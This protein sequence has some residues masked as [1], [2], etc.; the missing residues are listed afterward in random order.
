M[1]W[2]EKYRPKHLTDIL[3]NTATV[4]QM[5]TWAENWTTNSAPLLLTGKPGIGK[6]STA[7]AL[8]HD[9]NWEVLE[10]NAS[11]ARTKAII[12]RIA[13]NSATTSSLFGSSRKLIIID[14]ADNLEGNADKGGTRAI[15]DLL[16][17]AKQ[18]II[19]IA[20]DAYDVSSSIR[21]LT[22]AVQFRAISTSTLGKR[23]KDICIMEQITCSDDAI[24]TIAESA[25]GDLR[26]AINMLFGAGAGN[27]EI[28][29]DDIHTSQK[30]ERATI[31][32][33]VSGIVTGIPD[34]KLQILSHEC[35]EKP[36]YVIQWIEEVVAQIPQSKHRIRAYKRVAKADIYLGRTMIRQYYT[37]WRY[38]TS[39][40]TIGVA[41][42]GKTSFYQPRVLPPRRW[43]R[44]ATAKKQKSIKRS[45]STALSESLRIPD[46]Q[47]REEYLDLLGYVA[48]A[49]PNEFCERYSLDADQMEVLIHDKE[50]AIAAFK[51]VMK[52]AKEREIKIKKVAAKKKKELDKKETETPKDS[53]QTS[54]IEEQKQEEGSAEKKQTATQATFDF[55]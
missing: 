43:K 39:L 46:T 33:L 4:R 1:D 13:G 42:E 36:D 11:D 51:S 52:T 9:M 54:V 2:A 17:S 20:N 10:L 37:L 7:L 50:R 47:I 45:L 40:M 34:S 55:F 49:N 27:K 16:K 25:K 26:S 8:A 3:G 35:E 30:D 6:T 32:E 23:L 5:V 12:E 29:A 15:A 44:M 14:E 18:P 19:L 22:D 31:F 48:N 28:T 24:M 38:A 41:S 53:L 21:R